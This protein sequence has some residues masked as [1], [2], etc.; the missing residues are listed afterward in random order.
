MQG[1]SKTGTTGLPEVLVLEILSKLPVKSLTRFRCVCKPWSCSFQAP[2]FITKHQHNNLNLLFKGFHG[3]TRDGIHYFYQ[4]STEKGQNFSVKHK[5]HF[6]FFEKGWSG[7]AV[8]GLCNGI[9]C[10]HGA[11]KVALW[12][13][14]TREF[15]ILPQSS[16]QRPPSL[17]FTSLD[18]L[19]F[20]YDSQTNDYKV[21]RFVTN[22]FEEDSDAGLWF[23]PIHQVELYSLTSDSWK[24]MSV[25]EVCADGSP[26]FNNYVNGFYYWRAYWV[27]DTLILSFDM[28]NEKF[29]TL[30][31][32]QFD[33]GEDFYKELL[34]FNGLLAAI[35]YPREGTEKSFDLWVMNG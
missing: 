25:H 12:N 14:S 21:V 4:L 24:E 33:W 22:Y 34:D 7:L 19:G 30:P 1:F 23:D 15:K 8:D 28:V 3:N 18:G 16:V 11:D 6:P 13:P 29:S 26:L 10:L 32:P 27:P 5:F 20:G 17:H 35:F 31:L 9:L 2:L